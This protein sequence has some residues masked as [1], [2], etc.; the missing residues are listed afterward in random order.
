MT[1]SGGYIPK[2][3]VYCFH[4]GKKFPKKEGISLTKFEV[5]HYCGKGFNDLGQE[6][7]FA[8]KMMLK[9]FIG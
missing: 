5:C 4:C 2:S 9:T 3:Y 1:S 7:Q 6:A 8:V